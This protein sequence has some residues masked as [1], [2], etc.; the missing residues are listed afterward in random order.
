MYRNAKTTTD[1]QPHRQTKTLVISTSSIYEKFGHVL[2]PDQ[3]YQE[4]RLEGIFTSRTLEISVLKVT[5]DY[6][7]PVFHL[8]NLFARTEKK[9]NFT[10]WRQTLTSSPANYISFLLVRANKFAKWKTGLNS[11]SA[12]SRLSRTLNRTIKSC[13]VEIKFL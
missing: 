13:K 2:Q 4:R 1:V 9:S 11:S 10:G 7:K 8:A 12:H 3:D 6:V 5:R